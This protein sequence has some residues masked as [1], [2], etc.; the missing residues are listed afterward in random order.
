MN[1]PTSLIA[2]DTLSA[3]ATLSDY[4][5]SAGW[6]L[7]VTLVPRTAGAPRTLNAV[8][9]GDAFRIN[10]ASAATAGWSAG[11]CTWVARVSRDGEVH[12]VGQGQME[13]KPDPTTMTGGFDG[14]S[15]ALKALEDCRTALASWS[16]TRRRYK[17]GEREMEFR[18][19]AEIIQQITYWE[20]Q[21]NRETPGAR[22]AFS[23]RIY[24]RL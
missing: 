17:I 8:A 20:S 7:A 2:G 3:V 9:E 16:P 24:T 18:S 12:T 21:V 4:P 15:Q 5:A 1:L 19:T 6:S 22:P 13:I 11:V 14:R 23:G 10:A